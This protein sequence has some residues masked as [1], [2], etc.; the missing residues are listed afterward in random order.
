[1]SA[2]MDY[3]EYFAQ[4][5]DI[6]YD[7]IRS[8]VDTD[9]YLGRIRKAKGPVL[10]IGCG[11]GRFFSQAIKLGAD[12]YGIDISKS[13]VKFLLKKIDPEQHKRISIQGAA[14]FSFPF[15]FDL[16]IAPFRVYSHLLTVEEQ[17]AALN[18]AWAHLS[19]N[20]RLIF[21][22]Y[23]PDPGMI[24]SGL[25]N[26]VDF[27]GEYM[28]GKRISRTVN[29]KADIVN[30]ISDITMTF[31]W[32]EDE[33]QRSESWNFKFRFYFHYELRHLIA[34]S[35][36]TLEKIYGDFNEGDLTGDSKEFIVV[37]RR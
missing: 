36:L 21:D 1:M 34:R 37:C 15:K 16:I 26:V 32:D 11:T 12:V 10:E 5:Y 17:I 30:Q 19:D 4:F 18:N 23:V 7:S 8:H 31:K 25:S 2:S 33:I 6:I 28:P 3:P 35:K 20:G 13:M 22:L 27:E 9:F 24:A 29:M 14:D